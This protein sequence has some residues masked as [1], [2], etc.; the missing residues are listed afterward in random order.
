MFFTTAETQLNKNVMF[1]YITFILTLI[2]TTVN[3]CPF[4]DQMLHRNE[5][6]TVLNNLHTLGYE[7]THIPK[8]Q[9]VS[10]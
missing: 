8:Q 1:L 7:T 2:T 4:P 6:N 10:R 9:Q 3:P 5:E